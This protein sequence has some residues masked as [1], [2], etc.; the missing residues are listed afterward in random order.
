MTCT[1]GPVTPENG[2]AEILTFGEQY[3]PVCAEDPQEPQLTDGN[4]W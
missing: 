4:N 1:D 2:T 3:G